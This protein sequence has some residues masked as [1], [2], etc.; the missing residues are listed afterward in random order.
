MVLVLDYPTFFALYVHPSSDHIPVCT[1]PVLRVQREDGK[2]YYEIV[3]IFN[4]YNR[5]LCV[6][7][8]VLPTHFKN[9]MACIIFICFVYSLSHV[10]ST[11]VGR[12]AWCVFFL[13]LW[14][15]SKNNGP[16]TVVQG[17]QYSMYISFFAVKC[18]RSTKSNF[19]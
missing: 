7:L 13:F 12:F 18:I 4:L 15:P 6:E 3:F 16:A 14:I 19:E 10:V 5:I 9:K 2:A 11:A 1:T 17:L 8:M